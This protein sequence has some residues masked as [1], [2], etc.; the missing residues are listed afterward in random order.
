[1]ERFQSLR[2]RGVFGAWLHRREL[3]AARWIQQLR[4]LDALAVGASKRDI[5][6]V[7]FGV[8]RTQGEWRDHDSALRSTVRRLV[9]TA[10][11]NVAGGYR[12]MLRKG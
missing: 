6:A 2:R 1:M 9:S 8:R 11:Y 3:P 4:I 5:A 12:G 10:R 7:M